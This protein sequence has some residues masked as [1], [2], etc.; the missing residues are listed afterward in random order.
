MKKI[1]L[2]LGLIGFAAFANAADPLHGT[3]WKTV[4]DKTQKA[5]AI[6]KFTEQKNGTLTASIQQILTPGEENACSKCEGPYNGKSLKGLTIVHG[7]KNE[8]AKGKESY[9]GGT[10]LDPNSG[11]QYKLK[12]ELTQGGQKLEL[13]GFM[14][15]SVLGRNQ[16]WLRVN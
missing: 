14:G 4:D 13:R 6:V 10:I 7:L 1:A 15:V 16:T 3:T 8:K 11:K 9:V 12:G 5:K 2:A